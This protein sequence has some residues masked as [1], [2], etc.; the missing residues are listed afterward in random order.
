MSQGEGGSAA[1]S[2]ARWAIIYLYLESRRFIFRGTFVPGLLRNGTS[3]MVH[4]SQA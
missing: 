1:F 2:W 4:S 3:A